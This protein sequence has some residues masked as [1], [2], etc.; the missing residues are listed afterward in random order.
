MSAPTGCVNNRVRLEVVE[1]KLADFLG[2]LGERVQFDLEVADPR[3][4][5][6]LIP[7]GER[8]SALRELRQAMTEYVLKRLSK[9]QHGLL[10]TPGG[11]DLAEAYHLYFD[12]EANQKEA[13]IAEME[14]KIG[15][16]AL[17]RVGLAK[18]GVADR[19]L[20]ETIQELESRVECMRSQIVPLDRRIDAIARQLRDIEASIQAVSTHAKARR[21]RQAGESLKKILDRIEIYSEQSAVAVRGALTWVADRIVFKPLMGEPMEF[22][23]EWPSNLIR[24]EVVARAREI[25]AEQA[26]E[27][28]VNLTQ[29]AKRLT[30]EGHSMPT[31]KQWS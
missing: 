13:E 20:I 8:G 21:N 6:L 4:T 26:K 5:H 16:L 22:K 28:K 1:G 7:H 19:K 3:L 24:P 14:E 15:G 2:R 10:G 11:I 27:G 25:L 23:L 30:T 12:G 18:G 9:D 29:I 31:G 17:A